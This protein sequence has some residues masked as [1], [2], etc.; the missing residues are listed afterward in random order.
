[1]VHL[2]IGAFT[3]LQLEFLK[4]FEIVF[5]PIMR[6]IKYV[7][8]RYY[9]GS[10]LPMLFGLQIEL[11]TEKHMKF[12]T[13]LVEAL[14]NGFEKRFSDVMNPELPESVPLFVAMI[15]N[16]KYKLNYVPQ[17]LLSRHILRLKRMFLSAAEEMIERKMRKMNESQLNNDKE[18]ENVAGLSGKYKIRGI[19]FSHSKKRRR[20]KFVFYFLY[21]E[22]DD[23]CGL[24]KPNFRAANYVHSEFGS[25]TSATTEISNYL[26][27]PV[28][29]EA[30]FKD[31][32]SKFPTIKQVFQKFNA[33]SSSEAD[34]ERLFSYAGIN[35]FFGYLGLGNLISFNV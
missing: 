17:N 15:S 1:M 33:F 7:Q 34:C 23:D 8:G 6:A 11:N 19:Y 9:F 24:F 28:V 31:H 14:R 12:C 26:I 22:N 27:E 21:L 5:R 2:G 4:E 29:K 30:N 25:T 10:Y 18:S 32:L 13:P 20:I 3:D 35:S 16:P